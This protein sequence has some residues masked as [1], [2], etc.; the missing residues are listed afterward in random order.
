MRESVRICWACEY[1]MTRTIFNRF[2]ESIVGH[3]WPLSVYSRKLNKKRYCTIMKSFENNFPVICRHFEFVSCLPGKFTCM[4]VTSNG[5]Q[6]CSRGPKIRY[7]LPCSV[8]FLA[9]CYFFFGG[10]LNYH[11]YFHK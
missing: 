8:I 2:S 10:S 6:F 1:L 4:L 7:L 9:F 11:K 3:G 5:F